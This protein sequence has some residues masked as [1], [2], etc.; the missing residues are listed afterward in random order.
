[1][2]DLL[3]KETLHQGSDSAADMACTDW[4]EQVDVLQASVKHLKGMIKNQCDMLAL[5]GDS[6]EELKWAENDEWMKGFLNLRILKDQL[7][8]KL[9]S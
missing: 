7:L 4:Q 9:H 3:R 6:L 5:K 8:C 1:M 2:E